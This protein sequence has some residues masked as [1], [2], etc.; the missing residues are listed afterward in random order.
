MEVADSVHVTL[1]AIAL[2]D[3][4]NAGGS[5]GED[6]VASPELEEAGQECDLVRYVPDH[7]RKI[8]RLLAHAVDGEPDGARRWTLDAFRRHQRGARSGFLE[9]LRHLPWPRQLL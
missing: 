7:L 9:G 2:L 4:G 1:E 6:Q 5:A 8:A 3:G